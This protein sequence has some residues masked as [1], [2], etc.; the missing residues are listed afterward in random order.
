PVWRDRHLGSTSMQ[1]SL[2]YDTEPTVRS[3]DSMASQEAAWNGMRVGAYEP[4]SL[5]VDYEATVANHVK[6]MEALPDA[7]VTVI[8]RDMQWLGEMGTVYTC[9]YTH[10]GAPRRLIKL[11][12]RPGARP[13]WMSV[14]LDPARRDHL[15]AADRILK[16][17]RTGWTT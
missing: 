8:G 10:G 16:T 17:I 9:D 5:N 15:A 14:D 6:E 3:G 12:A 4:K 2:P 11:F 7:K 13:V 1:C